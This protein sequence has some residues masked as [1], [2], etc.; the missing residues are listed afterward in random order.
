[1]M[2]R[3]LWTMITLSV[4]LTGCMTI[5]NSK[6]LT[7]NPTGAPITVTSTARVRC[8]DVLTLFWFCNL[9]ME[10]ESSNGQKVSDFPQK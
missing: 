4:F 1:M 7:V 6:V 9:Y 10:M 3:A 2:R 5:Q 8:W